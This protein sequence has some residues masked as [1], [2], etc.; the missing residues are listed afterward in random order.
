[1]N[2]NSITLCCRGTFEIRGQTL[3]SAQYYEE[4][5]FYGPPRQPNSE[6]NDITKFYEWKLID[7]PKVCTVLNGLKLCVTLSVGQHCS[8]YSSQVCLLP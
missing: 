6:E 7:K 2:H 3:S 1:M 8:R 4:I 5:P